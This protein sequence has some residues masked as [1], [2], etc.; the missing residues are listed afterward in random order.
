[1]DLVSNT[2]TYCYLNQVFRQDDF[3][4][5][6]ERM[7]AADAVGDGVVVAS[8]LTTVENQVMGVAAGIQVRVVWVYLTLAT[9]WK[10]QLPEEVRAAVAQQFLDAIGTL[11]ASGEQMGAQLQKTR[12]NL[13]A[14]GDS[15]Y[16]AEDQTKELA[17]SVDADRASL[18]S[19]KGSW[20]EHELQVPASVSAVDLSEL[21]GLLLAA[22]EKG[23]AQD[24]GTPTVQRV[25]GVL[26]VFGCFFLCFVYSREK[27]GS[28]LFMPLTE[29]ELT[30]RVS[31][32]KPNEN[33]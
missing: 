30:E 3:A 9:N 23:K 19:I 26:V 1:M 27:A 10:A 5:L 4:P 22:S 31:Q 7:Q 20:T 15:D 14:G 32:T 18:A 25:L 13:K 28:P 16:G 2:S 6:V 8:D 21:G 24:P 11:H 17:A 29:S 33:L 12:L